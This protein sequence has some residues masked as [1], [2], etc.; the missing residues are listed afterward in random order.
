MLDQI[1]PYDV[2]VAISLIFIY[3][4]AMPDPPAF[5]RRPRHRRTDDAPRVEISDW[6]RIMARRREASLQNVCSFGFVSWN[7]LFRSAA[8]LSRPAY[9]YEWRHGQKTDAV[10]TAAKLEEG[11]LQI[12]NA[13]WGSYK[14]PSGYQKVNGDLTNVRWVEG[15]SAAAHRLL[16][17]IEHAS[18]HLPGSKSARHMMRFYTQALRILYGLP[19]FV[20]VSP[21]ESHN[22]LLIRFARTRQHDTLFKSY[23]F[24]HL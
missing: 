12:V 20:T 21:D 10:L 7:Y 15:L 3:C 6:V 23:R 5:M 13:L 2:G 24:K 22:L 11:A 19:V 9:A 18:R 17:N 16:Q 8:N 14:T 1:H 4:T